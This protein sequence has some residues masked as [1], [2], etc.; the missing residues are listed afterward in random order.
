MAAHN[1]CWFTE[2]VELRMQNANWNIFHTR[3]VPAPPHSFCTVRC[4]MTAHYSCWFTE[5][6]EL[7]MQNPNWNVFHARKVPAPPHSFCTARHKM[8]AHYSCWFTEDAELSTQN[9]NWNVFHA[10]KVPAPYSFGTARCKAP[11]TQDMYNVSRFAHK[12][13]CKSFDVACNCFQCCVNTPIG[14]N[15]FHFLCA[16]FASTSASCVNRA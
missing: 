1:S 9:T 11:F 5:D 4:K 15:V 8:A 14:N 10:R 12:F 3:K 16:T 13:A 6:A 7:R 2:D